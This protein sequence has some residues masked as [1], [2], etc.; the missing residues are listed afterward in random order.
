MTE[1]TLANFVE[2]HSSH[3]ASDKFIKTAG[4]VAG[5]LAIA[6]AR[7]RGDNDPAVVGLRRIA[8]KCGDVRYALRFCGGYCGVLFEA[9]NMQ[10]LTCLGGWKSSGIKSLLYMQSVSLLQY[11]VYENMA[12]LGWTAP[13]WI[14]K[15]LKRHWYDADE[16]GRLSCFGWAAWCAFDAWSSVLKLRELNGIEEVVVYNRKYSK[17][18]REEALVRISRCR[19]GLHLNIVRSLLFLFPT[20]QWCAKPGTLM[21]KIFPEWAVQGMGLAE[22]LIGYYTMWEGLGCSRPSLDD[23]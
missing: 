23:I 14:G 10:R 12:Y 11:Y 2:A 3:F 22:A 8:A 19:K 6:L 16:M 5:V 1:L 9:D 15:W 18:D 21:S 4:Y 17:N 20:L 7:I 13:G